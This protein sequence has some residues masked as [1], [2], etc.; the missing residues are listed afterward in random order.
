MC[1]PNKCGLFIFLFFLIL[2]FGPLAFSQTATVTLTGTITDANTGQ[3]LPGATVQLEGTYLGAA[4]GVSGFYSIERIKQGNYIIIAEMLGYRPVRS[5]VIMTG[6]TQYNFSLHPEERLLDEVMVRGIKAGVNTASTYTNLRKTEIEPLNKGQDLPFLLQQTPSVVV[7]SDAGAG[8]GYTGMRIRGTDATRINVTMNGIPLNDAE[9]HSVFWVNMPDFASSVDQIQVQR[10]VGTSANGAAAFGASVNLQTAQLR[11]QPYAEVNASGGSFNT[12]RYNVQLGT[13]LLNRHFTLD[14]RLSSITSDGYIDRAASNLKSFFL[15]G[16]YYGRKTIVRA[17]ILWGNEITYQAWGGVPEKLLQTRRTYNA[18]TYENQTDNYRQ[19]HYQLHFSQQVSPK[20]QLNAALHYTRG[21]G[22]YEEYQPMQNLTDY[23]LQN[24]GMYQIS[25]SGPDTLFL[26]VSQTDLIRRKWLDND[27]YGTLFTLNYN[28]AK[29]I[30]ATI[31]GGINRYNG[32]HFGEVIWAQY[33]ANGNI[34]HRY[35]ESNGY[36]TDAN[37]FAKT[38]YRLSRQLGLFADVQY[39]HIDYRIQGTDEAKGNITFDL[40]YNFINPKAGITFN[41]S[42]NQQVYASFG[43]AHREPTR[44]NLIDNDT[45]PLP[46]RLSNIEAGYRFTLSNINI[47][48]NYYYM[49]YK[50]QLVLTGNLN[51]V[52]YPIQQNVQHSYRTGFELA[53][54]VKAGNKLDIQANLTSSINKIDGFSQFT[55]VF[56][57]NY[58]YLR[59]TTLVYNHTDIS[60]SPNV[61]AAATLTY[62]PAKWASAAF[63]ANYVDRQFL[64][65]TGSLARSLN[66]YFTGNLL[67]T[68]SLQPK[69]WVKNLELSLLINNLF[70][71]LYESN[72][73]TYFLL[74]EREGI[75]EPENYN[76]Y[77]PQAGT[78]LLAGLKVQW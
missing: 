23:G 61:T 49:R 41:V 54:M 44:N 52:G 56:D 2:L 45:L 42:S 35:Y 21:A 62:R 24:Q 28:S 68:G 1:H 58:N 15:S 48:A 60:F 30:H 46:E 32:L 67:L 55:G 6:N 5:E 47:N 19:H 33:A 27:F 22:Y 75:I 53:L 78:N 63:M 14:G 12:Q 50:N 72:G 73:W 64:D 31:G 65:N 51:N 25:V 43:M 3:P 13:G 66:P 7:T 26:P 59:D 20:W 37:L 77:Y 74:M 4:A 34:N 29:K 69:K 38:E 71:T 70:N 17:N 57:A 10:G 36:K 18:Y 40:N 9:S 16:G 39:R 11:P 76:N 8:V